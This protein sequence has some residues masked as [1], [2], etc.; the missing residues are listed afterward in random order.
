MT[1][2]RRHSGRLRGGVRRGLDRR[3]FGALALCALLGGGVSAACGT[4]SNSAPGS[5][6]PPVP[7]TVA[8]LAGSFTTSTGEWVNL[9]MGSSGLNRFWELVA[10][11]AAGRRWALA[12]PPGVADNGGL[13]TAGNPGR[14]D[15]VAGFIPSQYL[16]VSPLETS[17]DGGRSWGRP[18]I[19]PAGLVAG[20]GSLS[21]APLA[22][23]SDGVPDITALI[24]PGRGQVVAGPAIGSAWRKV[25]NATALGSTR[26]GRSCRPSRLTGVAVG[27]AGTTY[28]SSRCSR[29]GAAG[30]FRS[31]GSS[32]RLTGP[33]LPPTSKA[34]PVTVLRLAPT[35]TGTAMLLSWD[36]GHR[37]S[38]IAAW[39][40]SGSTDW[41]RTPVLTLPDQSSV[42]A[43]GL[44]PTGTLG[45]VVALP[46]DAHGGGK[47]EW[48]Y[49]ATPAN[50]S[51]SRL[52]SPP[53]GTVSVLPSRSAGSE[54]FVTH[55]TTLTVFSLSPGTSRWH[56]TARLHVKIPYGSST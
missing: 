46:A 11:T 39:S 28:V 35:L 18:A 32:W 56:R 15:V 16:S 40:P 54:A 31:V 48:I 2:R 21:L 29:P 13:V 14:A 17:D 36:A 43:I 10:G 52:P 6:Q 50:R 41:S 5:L 33:V 24:G 49:E 22:G 44:G 45:I 34:R 42:T 37:L 7:T 38:V 51:W 9:P 25:T 4:S 53:Q 12:T 23:G 55:R 1:P 20:P 30:V 27:P 26:S 8:P 3:R 19:L 47:G